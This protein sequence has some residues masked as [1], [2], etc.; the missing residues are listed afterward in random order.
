MAA[1]LSV[2]L[3]FLLVSP[4]IGFRR[5]FVDYS[6]CDAQFVVEDGGGSHSQ[7]EE[8]SYISLGAFGLSG[9]FNFSLIGTPAFDT[10]G[11]ISGFYTEYSSSTVFFNN[12]GGVLLTM[13]LW[14]VSRGSPFTFLASALITLLCAENG[15][16]W[17]PKLDGSERFATKRFFHN[18][19]WR[20]FT[21]SA[22]QR[23]DRQP[24]LRRNWV[25]FDISLSIISEPHIPTVLI[26]PD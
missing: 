13:Q 25:S 11:D 23:F 18:L 3:V 24:W 26:F 9:A 17:K 4:W 12:G 8:E 21:H 10:W 16:S 20:R 1:Q 19:H 6:G 7:L 14:L 15:Y 5:G 2:L 22:F